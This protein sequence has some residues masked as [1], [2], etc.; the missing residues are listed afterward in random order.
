MTPVPWS[1]TKKEKC[2]FLQKSVEYLGHRIDQTGVHTSAEK[3]KAVV[4][5]PSPHNSA[6]PGDRFLNCLSLDR[7][8]HRRAAT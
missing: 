1:T 7:S 3:V 5:A 2:Q 4:N 6:C 8:S